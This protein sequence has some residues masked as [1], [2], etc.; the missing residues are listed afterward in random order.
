MQYTRLLCPRQRC[1]SARHKGL[2]G[3][4]AL[5]GLHDGLLDELR[6]R[7]IRMQHGFNLRP[8][9]RGDA[10]RGELGGFHSRGVVQLLCK[11]AA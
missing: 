2:L 8:H 7:F 10:Y 6:Q 4:A 1:T 11:D 5:R 9:G 3:L